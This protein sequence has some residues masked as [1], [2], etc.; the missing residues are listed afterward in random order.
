MYERTYLHLS[1]FNWC[2]SLTVTVTFTNHTLVLHLL[3]A[4]SDRLLFNPSRF[5]ATYP[6]H[7][8]SCAFD[9]YREAIQVVHGSVAAEEDQEAPGKK[10]R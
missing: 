3:P 7:A 8:T 4:K 10:A 2:V 5:P 6:S 1:I 9:P